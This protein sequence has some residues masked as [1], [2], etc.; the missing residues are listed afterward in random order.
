MKLCACVRD[1]R[2]SFASSRRFAPLMEYCF[3]DGFDG[4]SRRIAALCMGFM[5]SRKFAFTPLVFCLS[6]SIV[7]EC[8]SLLIY[9]LQGFGLYGKS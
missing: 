6:L 4:C 2:F 9:F 5:T 1:R 7:T 8:I 3:A